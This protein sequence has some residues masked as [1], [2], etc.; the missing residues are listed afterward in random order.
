MGGGLFLRGWL[1]ALAFGVTAL[2]CQE[3]RPPSENLG[4]SRDPVS[5]TNTQTWTSGAAS[6]WGGV[7]V[8][9]IS[10]QTCTQQC[11]NGS[12]PARGT[13]PSGTS[14][15]VC[16]PQRGGCSGTL[17]ARDLVLTAGHCLCD[18]NQSP[19]SV[20][21]DISINF[22]GMAAN[23]AIHSTS[24]AT[25]VDDCEGTF[26]DDSSK[27][28]AMIRLPGNVDNLTV[29]SP[30][31][32]PYLGDLSALF[33]A[34][35]FV[36]ATAGYG[37]DEG[38]DFGPPLKVATYSG[39]IHTDDDNWFA[40][41][42]SSGSWWIY[43]NHDGEGAATNNGDSGG[44]LAVLKNSDQSWYEIGLTS[45]GISSVPGQSERDTFTPLQNNGDGN[46]T[47][48][49]G[50]LSDADGD[51]VTDSLDNC[52]P[53]NPLLTKCARDVTACA[54]QDQLDSDG[55]GI[56]DACDNCPMTPN[57]SQANFDGDLFGDACDGCPEMQGDNTDSD[58]DGVWNSCDNCS[59]SN[60]YAACSSDADCG[61]GFCR[62]NGLCSRQLDDQD[63]DG[64]GGPC[65]QCPTVI[66]KDR[67]GNS[68][69]L[70]E[71]RKGVAALQDVCDP[72]PL[73]VVAPLSD[74]TLPGVV[75]NPNGTERTFTNTLSFAASAQLGHDASG[76]SAPVATEALPRV[77]YAGKAGFRYCDCDTDDGPLSQETCFATRCPVD[78]HEYAKSD[79]Q[80]NWKRVT[81]AT[82]GGDYP[83]LSAD[84]ARG[85]EISRTF[86]SDLA[87]VLPSDKTLPR[88]GAT[89]S[90]F[91]TF[92][93]DLTIN[94][95]GGQVASKF[96]DY[97]TEV[98]GFFWSH[99][100]GS[101]NASARDSAT[102]QELRDT[103]E[104]VGGP[105]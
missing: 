35:F 102:S 22:P 31:I 2:S 15:Y 74:T 73:Y 89:E 86:T 11:S 56:G 69:P 48:I 59:L 58:G 5:G 93:K 95:Q 3:S 97:I 45:R 75:P 80:T 98:N 20:L 84:L 65:D 4:T 10:Y 79:T 85:A 32:K 25:Y 51:Q 27:D 68:N 40:L 1:W 101:A 30:L 96:R 54:N 42:I 103:Y 88:L 14:T 23:A 47:W 6:P 105:Y 70:S 21:N 90:L 52:N 9:N 41:G 61:G 83:P 60:G 55:D 91:W 12:P 26:E 50:F 92:W 37:G 57:P 39:D 16:T 46:A 44:P 82:T 8:I 53:S 7:G 99:A 77:T 29:N 71:T 43:T 38:P 87:A 81:I 64:V 100:L 94:G 36:A 49:A 13:C 63:G 24:F 67:L 18:T 28:L 104:P 78:P 17:I 72:V 66:E 62:E 34:G 76:L 19:F 33:K